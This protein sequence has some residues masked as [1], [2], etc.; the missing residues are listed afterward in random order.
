V[1]KLTLLPDR[2]NKDKARLLLLARVTEAYNR[3]LYKYTKSNRGKIAVPR[4]NT[5]EIPRKYATINE[6][7]N[8][9][10]AWRQILNFVKETDG[11]NIEEYLNVMFRN[12][13]DVAV[14]ANIPNQET[15]LSS[16]IFSTKVAPLFYKYKERERLSEE[17]NK[18]LPNRKSEDFYRLTPSLQS[19]VN[20][21]F[22]LK[23]LNPDIPYH[24]IVDIFKGEFEDVFVS[25][26]KELDESEITV[27]NLMRV[28]K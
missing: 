21:L 9:K 7:V 1:S 24:E 4:T 28:F 5:I 3:I 8:S 19:N 10:P 27:E 17:L 15:P 25:K 26:V 14:H 6:Y 16:V 11:V 13:R 20:S 23:K 2:L 18:H 12:W 22:R